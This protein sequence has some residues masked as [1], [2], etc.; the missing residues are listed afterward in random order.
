MDS[1]IQKISFNGRVKLCTSP[2]QVYHFI[3][4]FLSVKGV[5]ISRVPFLLL[6]V[7]SN[8]ISLSFFFLNHHFRLFILSFFFFSFLIIDRYFSI[9]IILF[10]CILFLIQIPLFSMNSFFFRGQRARI[11]ESKR[12]KEKDFQRKQ[13]VFLQHLRKSLVTNLYAEKIFSCR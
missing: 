1:V 5:T 10:L 8:N 3:L 7:I 2:E 12:D 4:H 11:N 9:F 13:F 6:G